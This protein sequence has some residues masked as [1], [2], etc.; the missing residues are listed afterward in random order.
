M[1]DAEGEADRPDLGWAAGVS[2][3]DTD[4]LV[5]RVKT[6]VNGFCICIYLCCPL[7]HDILGRVIVPAY[8]HPFL[9]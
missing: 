1:A 6:S 3:L 7:S 9:F 5:C 4:H 8:S 2:D